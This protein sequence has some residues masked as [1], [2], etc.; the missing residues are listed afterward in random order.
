MA[1][2]GAYHAAIAVDKAGHIGGGL[3][4]RW[5]TQRLVKFFGPYLLNQPRESSMS[6]ALVDA[7]MSSI[8][9]SGSIG[10]I[11]RCPTPELPKQYFESL[12]SLT[13]KTA[14]GAATEI[15]SC[16]R[17]LEEDAGLAVWSHPSLEPFLDKEYRRLVFARE[18]R[19][20][21]DEGERSSPYSVLSAEFDRGSSRV[22]L[23]PIW[24]GEDARETVSAHI[25]ALVKENIP[26][27]FF[28][29]DLGKSWQ[30]HYAPALLDSG[31]E[32]RLVLP[33]AGYGDL[34]VFQYRAGA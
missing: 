23:Y 29:M 5:E 19:L 9:R 14:A 22:T 33:Y 15:A 31:F 18:I 12:G 8:A 16:Y 17:H 3:V 30:C 7:C 21:R 34:V 28:E 10:L 2:S 6:Q 32:P 20:V 4:W 1:A 26:N 27:I 11:N 13:F 25:E 24:L